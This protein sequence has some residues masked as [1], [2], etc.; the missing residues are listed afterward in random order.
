MSFED[1]WYFTFVGHLKFGACNSLVVKIKDVRRPKIVSL[2]EVIILRD[3]VEFELILAQEPLN[4][5]DERFFAVVVHL[6]DIG[7]CESLLLESE[8]MWWPSLV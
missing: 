5:K 4:F 3:V 8:E 2:K 6:K 7:N 1:D